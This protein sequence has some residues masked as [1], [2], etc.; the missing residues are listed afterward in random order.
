MYAFN[1]YSLLFN[2]FTKLNKFGIIGKLLAS[3]ASLYTF[4]LKRKK[5]IWREWQWVF[6][7]FYLK[8]LQ[9]WFLLTKSVNV[10][11]VKILENDIWI[12]VSYR[13]SIYNLTKNL[14]LEKLLFKYF[15]WNW[16]HMLT[17]LYINNCRNEE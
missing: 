4:S 13:F 3:G 2:E 5:W 14:T 6:L 16:E 17:I 11:I 8:G 10:A 1:Q 15:A 7:S 9:S 12:V